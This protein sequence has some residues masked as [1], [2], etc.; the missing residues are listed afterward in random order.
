MPH[1]TYHGFRFVELTGYPGTPS[2]ATLE[3]IHVGSALGN[4]GHI[5]FSDNILNR[6]QSNILWGQ[7]SNLMSVPTDCDQRGKKLLFYLFS[8][9]FLYNI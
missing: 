1:F 9:F 7:Q 6:I 4:T 5:S 3:G 2:L 8:S